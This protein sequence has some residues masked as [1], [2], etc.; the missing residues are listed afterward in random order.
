MR[1]IAEFV[2]KVPGGKTTERSVLDLEFVVCQGLRFQ[3]K[4]HHAHTAAQ[5]ILL[6]MQ[7]C[8]RE[9]TELTLQTTGVAAEAL[10]K[11]RT[12]VERFIRASRLTDAE[13][14]HAPSHIAL[15]AFLSA[16]RG[17]TQSW[18]E[19][20]QR[21]TGAESAPLDVEGLDSLVAAVEGRLARSTDVSVVRAIDLRLKACLSA[22]A[23]A[24]KADEP[25]KA[26]KSAAPSADPFGAPL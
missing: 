24:R 26:V 25:P 13:F 2:A 11:L 10:E 23:S 22:S 18:I 15:A 20:K 9:C 3:F 7:V 8:G 12:P 14:L 5:G 4:V 1:P 17:A 6:D 21:R 19:E 16:D